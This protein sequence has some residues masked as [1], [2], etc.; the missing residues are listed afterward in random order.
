[1]ATLH[2]VSLGVRTG[3]MVA[4]L[5]SVV[6]C[7]VIVWGS[8][9][10]N[11]FSLTP[12][13][14]H[15]MTLL[16]LLVGALAVLFGVVVLILRQTV[17]KQ[18]CLLTQQLDVLTTGDLSHSLDD[19]MTGELGDVGQRIN[20][21]TDQLDWVLRIIK[22]QARSVAAVVQELNPLREQL[23]QDSHQSKQ[24]S[25][26]VTKENDRLDKE[27]QLLNDHVGAARDRI[28]KV[29]TAVDSLSK[30]ISEIAESAHQADSNVSTMASAAEEMTSN[31]DQ[32][33]SSL[34]RV[35]DSVGEVSGAVEG[36]NLSLTD[37]RARCDTADS[38]SKEANEKS[39]NT[40][41]VMRGLAV[42]AEEVF[43]AV[44]TIRNI[45]DQTNMLA[46]NAAIE[47][48]GAGEAGKGFAVVA[49]EVKG[50]ASQTADATAMIEGRMKQMRQRTD[51][52]MNATREVDDI[53]GNLSKTNQA[54]TDAV[55]DQAAGV[56]E[57]SHSMETVTLAADEVTRNAA[58][59]S[60]AAQEVARSALEAA[61][62]TR[63]IADTASQLATLS[64]EVAQ[65]SDRAQEESDK[66]QLGAKE[67][68]TSSVGVQKRM[69]Q[70]IQL[71]DFLHGSVEH[72]GFLTGVMDA[73]DRSLQDTARGYRTTK[74]PFDVKAVKQAHLAWLGKLEHVIRGRSVMKPDEMASGRECA[75]GK[76]YYS[77]GEQ[78]FGHLPLF[79]ELGDVH[80]KVHEV[81]REVVMLANNHDI[82]A[83]VEGM[84]KFDVLR[85]KL[86]EQLDQLYMI[87]VTAVSED[88][89]PNLMPWNAHLSTGVGQMDDEHGVLVDLVNQLYHSILKGESSSQGK[90]IL[91][92]LITYTQTHFQQEEALMKK[93]GYPDF[94]QHVKEHQKLLD[95]VVAF[96][97]SFDQGQATINLGL[98]SF[99]KD[100]LT[101]HIVGND[102]RYGPYMG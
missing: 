99:L 59:L 91:E 3:L 5:L 67:I 66:V 65:Q 36:L 28:V 41:E 27:I 18:V 30:N 14:Q 6:L 16:L 56:D 50:L 85:A 20:M 51:D 94:D 25:R 57:I 52:A 82:E 84:S 77:E 48:A 62:G 2:R 8:W 75:F 98:V 61:Q 72:A 80:L 7:G 24:L 86:F 54:I 34:Q 64:E 42:D 92:A 88:V 83:A 22:L 90:P 29:S 1:M 89:Q 79:Q 76:W 97:A 58:E 17:L 73:T 102:K 15:F 81:A 78:K 26:E 96:K 101:N 60:V 71:M 19:G 53:I 21:L 12:E 33:N 4:G 47:S 9:S 87:G 11:R 44:R 95:Q 37:V 43:K 63:I 74:E 49:N 31:I 10:V 23:F 100:W 40:R 46:L 55:D 70:S 13:V 32:V 68:F 38:M 45:A 93:V 69:I 35:N 39:H